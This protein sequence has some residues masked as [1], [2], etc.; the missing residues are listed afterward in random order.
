MAAAEGRDRAPVAAAGWRRCE[1]GFTPPGV[2][3][4]R[5][6]SHG[7]RASDVIGLPSLDWVCAFFHFYIKKQNFKNICRIWKF[8]KIGTG[9]LASIQWAT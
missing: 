8:S 1:L 6:S 5:V 7:P 3:P 2:A 9:C 4:G